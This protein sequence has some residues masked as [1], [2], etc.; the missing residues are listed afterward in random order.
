MVTR[1]KEEW[2]N[3]ALNR[4]GK[5]GRKRVVEY[6]EGRKGKCNRKG[7]KV[8]EEQKIVYQKSETNFKK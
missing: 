8:K 2:G 5:G 4:E 7:G 1:G 6:R 3:I